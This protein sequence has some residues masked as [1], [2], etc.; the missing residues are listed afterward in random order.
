MT[1]GV[2]GRLFIVA[3]P[4][5]NLEDMTLRAL[6]TL[7]EAAL[8]ASEDT[9]HTRKLLTHFGIS[10]PLMSC[11]REKEL[12]C[13]TAILARL[14]AGEDVAVVSDAGTPGIADPGALVVA[15]VRAAGFQVVPVPG[16]S[17][18][19]AAVSAAGFA[20][21]TFLFLGFLPSRSGERRKALAARAQCR[22]T[23]VFYESPQ[24][25]AA[26]LEDCLHAFGDRQ[27][28]FAR[29]LTKVHEEIAAGA[30]A[31]LLESLRGRSSIKGEFVV[32]IAGAG[33][34][35]RPGGEA[36]AER[37]R[38][39]RGEGGSLRDA[40]RQVV[41]ETGAPRGEVYRLA[42]TFWKEAD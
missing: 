6:R 5:G 19:A 3:T 38:Q 27:A 42:L 12:E 9:R 17:A 14:A 2:K 23:L 41:E 34:P 33:E 35:E 39:L 30:L 26:S 15:R 29:E 10:T 31:S 32:L 36:V 7:K 28:V 22:D 37:L 4:I 20:E 1:A 24:R 25:I 18:L 13:S 16:P 40:V 8:I 21:P 11:Y